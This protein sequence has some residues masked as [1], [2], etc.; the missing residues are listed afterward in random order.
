MKLKKYVRNILSRLKEALES[1]NVNRSTGI[2]D[3]AMSIKGVRFFGNIDLGENVKTF[4]GVRIDAQ[5]SVKVGRF[6]SING[7]G[8]EICCAINSIEIGAFCS[9]ARQVSIQEYDHRSDRISTS[10]IASSIFGLTKNEDL[11]S[12]GGI[13]I[14]NDV[15]IGSKVTI[16]S[17]VT[18][19]NGAII[20]A[21]SVVTKDVEPYAIVGGVPAKTIKMRFD[22][23]TIE[24][25]DKIQWWDW[26]MDKIRRNKILF[27]E[28]L[29]WK[30]LDRIK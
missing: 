21:N 27:T 16:T 22:Q 11:V 23:T 10:G 29:D 17:G 12:K 30:S 5:S 7:P 1:T 15:W 19:G 2:I 24:M 18:I 28:T 6:T 26:D 14:G 13:S 3:E 25:L 4:P 20:A 8:T 9:I